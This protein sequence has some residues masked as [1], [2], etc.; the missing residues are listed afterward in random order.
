M[1]MG[2]PAD[3]NLND[4]KLF[5]TLDFE[6]GK[7]VVEVEALLGWQVQGLAEEAGGGERGTGRCVLEDVPGQYGG[8]DGCQRER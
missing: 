4:L 7:A 2:L 5:T 6:E 3:L 8:L 1:T